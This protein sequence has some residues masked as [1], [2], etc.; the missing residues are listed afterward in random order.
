MRDD[1]HEAGQHDVQII[2]SLALAHDFGM[3]GI[4]LDARG[5]EDLV[6]RG[7]G[8]SVLNTAGSD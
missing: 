1:L 2:G 5:R 4:V 3:R 8:C 7:Q 6:D